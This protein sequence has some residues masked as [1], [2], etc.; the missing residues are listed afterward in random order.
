MKKSTS[1]SR[2][3]HEERISNLENRMTSL[4]VSIEGRFSRL[5]EKL[6]HISEGI[7]TTLD[8]NYY[9]TNILREIKGSDF[10]SDSDKRLAETVKR[11]ERWIEEGKKQNGKPV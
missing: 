7:G 11:G 1:H 9:I 5:D 4:E 8:C 10:S 3:T 6:D 2:I